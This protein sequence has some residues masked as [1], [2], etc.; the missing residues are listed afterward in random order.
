L[1]QQPQRLRTTLKRR[2]WSGRDSS[3]E[4][5]ES[6]PWAFTST[7]AGIY[8]E[9]TG[10]PAVNVVRPSIP[11]DCLQAI[12]YSSTWAVAGPSTIPTATQPGLHNFLAKYGIP[13]DIPE[14]SRYA[15]AVLSLLSLD[16][17]DAQEI[18]QST[19]QVLQLA[20]DNRRSMPVRK[21]DLII[22]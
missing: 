18:S 12:P 8:L 14:W 4:S 21:C 13:E 15:T 19:T 7:E 1:Q 5:T 16:Q 22:T 6:T 3:E 17:G 2:T 20:C 11:H 9:G 10:I